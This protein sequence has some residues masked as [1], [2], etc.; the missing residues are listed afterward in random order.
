MAAR[1]PATPST[2]FDLK[3]ASLALVALV[4]RTTRLEEL[5]A[6]FEARIA[7]SADFF[8]RDPVVIDLTHV[9]DQVEPVDFAGLAALLR[10][11]SMVPVAVRSGSPEQLEAALE[12]GLCEAPDSGADLPHARVAPPPEP[13]AAPEPEPVAPA[14]AAADATDPD[15]PSEDEPA[16]PVPTLLVVDRPLRSGQ[17]VYAK[18]ADLVVLALVSHGAEVIADGSIHVYAPLRGKAIA[19]AT[20]DISARIFSTC[21]EPELISVAGI[22]QTTDPPLPVEV[23]GKAAQVRLDGDTLVIEAIKA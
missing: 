4:L 5:E 3:S 1:S 7:P 13:V 12:A 8:N 14:E 17:Q 15:A 2:Q 11:Y 16:L 23:R 22:Y 19:G 9:R 18:N 6:Q 10:R 21:M 20:G